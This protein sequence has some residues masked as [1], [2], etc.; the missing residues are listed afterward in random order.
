MGPLCRPSSV[1]FLMAIF[2]GKEGIVLF[3]ERHE[4]I[5]Y[6]SFTLTV[7]VSISDDIEGTVLNILQL[8]VWTAGV[9]I[10]ILWNRRGEYKQYCAFFYF[11]I[12]HKFTFPNSTISLINGIMIWT[13]GNYNIFMIYSSQF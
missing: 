4:W 10:Y 5:M 13:M 9:L 11:T 8:D 2:F 12:E 7:V 6:L 3:K 1:T